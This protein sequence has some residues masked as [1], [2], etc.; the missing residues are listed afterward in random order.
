MGL[1]LGLR[2]GLRVAQLLEVFP[3][4]GRRPV[5]GEEDLE[6]VGVGVCADP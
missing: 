3:W 1:G 4:E 5:E 2:F 6:G